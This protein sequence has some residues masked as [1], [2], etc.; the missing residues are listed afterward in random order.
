MLIKCIN[1]LM[2]IRCTWTFIDFFPENKNFSHAY[3][4]KIKSLVG[5]SAISFKLIQLQIETTIHRT[6]FGVYF[7]R[8]RSLVLVLWPI[9]Q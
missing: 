1:A 8:I 5:K 9:L 7:M 6:L 3:Y 2:H 4:E